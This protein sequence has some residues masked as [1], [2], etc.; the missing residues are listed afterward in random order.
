M[1]KFLSVSVLSSLLL[2][3]SAC[4]EDEVAEENPDVEG[5]EHLEEGPATA[6]TASTGASAPAVD[7]DHRRYD[8][9]LVDVAGGKGGSVTFASSEAG[10]FV[11]FLGENVP[12]VVEDAAGSVV[13][14][15][16]S[17]A[18]SATCS[19]IKARHQLELGVG[20]YSLRFGPSSVGAVSLVLEP[21]A[22]A[23]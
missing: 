2:L 14:F 21:A 16:S 20:T 8:V 11:L 13:E 23:H 10:D 3:T 19:A 12:V 15:E 18:G 22:H 6:I 17:S 9:T 7:D 1:K 4:G 5:C